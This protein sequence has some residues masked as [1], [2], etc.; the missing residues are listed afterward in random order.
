MAGNQAVTVLSGGNVGIGTTNPG[1]GLH[2]YQTENSGTRATVKIEAGSENA[3]LSLAGRYPT[4]NALIL[5]KGSDSTLRIN[6]VG[7]SGAAHLTINPSGNVGVGTAA[8]VGIF[9]VDSNSLVV[10]QNGNVGIGTASPGSL[11]HVSGSG[12]TLSITDTQAWSSE[13]NGPVIQLE[14]K[15]NNNTNYTFAQIKGFSPAAGVNNAG[16][17]AIFTRKSGV[18]IERVRIDEDGN[19]GI[20]TT[21]PNEALHVSGNARI[22]GLIYANGA[23]YAEYFE[24]EEDMQPGDVAGINMATGKVRKYQSD[25]QFVGIISSKAGFVGNSERKG[26]AGY[27]LVGLVGQLDVNQE[28]ARIRGRTVEALDGKKIGVLLSNGKVFIH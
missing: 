21:N 26:V 9:Q 20:G 16:Q 10:S 22:S 19:V 6:N 23:D 25:D 13:A 28:Q 14:G 4:K 12:P 2:V 5:L 17:L 15:T 11:V 3:Y 24:S 18:D 7:S 1:A 27:V 8:Q